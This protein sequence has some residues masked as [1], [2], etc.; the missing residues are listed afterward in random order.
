MGS[1]DHIPL[2]QLRQSQPAGDHSDLRAAAES[3]RR[4]DPRSHPPVTSLY[5]HVPFCSHKCHYCDFYSIVDTQDRMDLFCDRLIIELRTLAPH[6]HAQPLQTIFV[7]GGTP[8]L[9]GPARWSRLLHALKDSFD[10]SLMS[11]TSNEVPAASGSGIHIGEFTIECNPESSS[12]ELFEVFAA[13]G[14]NRVSIGAQSFNTAHLKTLERWHDP[15]NVFK[16]V[17]AARAGGIHRQSLDLIFAVP[18]Q[19]IAEWLLDLETAISAGTS[20]IS[21]YNLTYEPNTAMT[22]RLQAGAFTPIDEETE[23]EMFSRTR[24]RLQA[25]GLSAYEVSNFAHTEHGATTH[26]QEC[27]HNLAY[28]RQQQWLAAG[29]GASGHLFASKDRRAGG[30]RWKNTPRLGDYLAGD[31]TGN[32]GW[33]APVSDVEHPDPARAVRERVMTGL[34]L[35]EGIARDEILADA[36]SATAGSGAHLLARAKP[37]EDRALLLVSGDRWILSE[38]AMLRADG[39]AAD[40]MRAIH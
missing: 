7:G 20:H 34:R 36:D 31:A 13:G 30:W 4:I 33:H 39:I 2:T 22:Q 14:V 3:L 26:S 11:A 6:T 8:S 18:G 27:R 24:Q 16:A 23:I 1:P 32:A 5:V 17:E 9:L 37:Y 21:C 19:T 25:A 28:W 15:S 38:G 40:L 29:P 12:L 10:L 35:R